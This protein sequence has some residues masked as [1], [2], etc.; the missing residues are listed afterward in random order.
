[1]S[2]QREE[3][4]AKVKEFIRDYKGEE[5][6]AFILELNSY[7]FKRLNSHSLSKTDMLDATDVD[8]GLMQILYNYN[9]LCDAIDSFKGN[10][11]YNN[12]SKYVNNYNKM[13]NIAATLLVERARKRKFPGPNGN[14]QLNIENIRRI[15]L[16]ER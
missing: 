5:N 7:L 12:I 14:S 1:M 15:E 3:E 6:E 4:I 13:E 2:I 11:A 10:S 16:D 9:Y 8:F